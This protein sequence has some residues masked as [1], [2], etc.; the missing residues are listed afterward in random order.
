MHDEGTTQGKTDIAHR[1]NISGSNASNGENVQCYLV[2]NKLAAPI[3]HITAV[4]R[5]GPPPGHHMDI[6]LEPLRF[7]VE[8]E[9]DSR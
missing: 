4:V 8:F 9:N 5:P 6:Q 1:S 7:V 3:V 2:F